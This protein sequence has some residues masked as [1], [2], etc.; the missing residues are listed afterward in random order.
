MKKFKQYV[1]LLIISSFSFLFVS[2]V[3]TDLDPK[4]IEKFGYGSICVSDKGYPQYDKYDESFFDYRNGKFYIDKKSALNMRAILPEGKKYIDLLK[5][6]IAKCPNYSEDDALEKIVWRFFASHD[7]NGKKIYENFPPSNSE[8]LKELAYSTSEKE[9]AF[10]TA[11]LSLRNVE[12]RDWTT[13]GMP[14]NNGELIP[15]IG[16]WLNEAQTGWQLYIVHTV[17]YLEVH[18][19]NDRYF[20][21]DPIMTT[22][23]EIK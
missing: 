17:G 11:D 1:I 14:Y 22:T 10:V 13:S 15:L 4:Y 6:F 23:V 19:G 16:T 3:L 5:D 2:S 8:M 18:R 21:D 20:V 9:L 7:K 12:A